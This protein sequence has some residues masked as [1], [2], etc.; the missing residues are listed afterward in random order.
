[1]KRDGTGERQVLAHKLFAY[2]PYSLAWS[3][4]GKTI[5]FET[6]SSIECI[7]ISLVDVGSGSVQT[8]DL[9]HAPREVTVAPAWQPAPGTAD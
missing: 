9:L 1:M 2:A 4:D 6:S 5:A 7:S 8:S 3:P